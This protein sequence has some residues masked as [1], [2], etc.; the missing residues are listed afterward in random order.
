MKQID[1]IIKHAYLITMNEKR[2]IIPDACI[3]VQGDKILEVGTDALLEQYQADR[4]IDATG[5]YVFP[6]FISTHSHLFQTML[7][8]LG[9][10]YKRQYQGCTH[11]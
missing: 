6:G 11:R 7:K 2:E 8:G 5:K 10:V 1:L 9:D 4:V 3:A